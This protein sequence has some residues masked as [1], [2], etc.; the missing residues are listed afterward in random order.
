MFIGQE[1]LFQFLVDSV[2][3]F[4]FFNSLFL[5]IVSSAN[6]LPVFVKRKLIKNKQ[7]TLSILGLL[8]LVLKEWLILVST[9]GVVAL[10]T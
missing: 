4:F 10:W 2:L 7:K 9:A 6:Y 5:S 8:L 1:T 3:F